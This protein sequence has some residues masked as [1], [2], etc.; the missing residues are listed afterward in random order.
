MQTYG[1]VVTYRCAAA[2]VFFSATLY[3]ASAVL[4][5]QRSCSDSSE[6]YQAEGCGVRI[7]E[8]REPQDSSV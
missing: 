3:Y 4:L 5:D 6:D 7:D 2:L 1:S 8:R